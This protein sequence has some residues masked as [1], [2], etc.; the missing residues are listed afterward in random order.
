[1]KTPLEILRARFGYENF[2][3][4]QEEVIASVLQKR[5]TFVL[6]PTGGGKSLCYQIP[7]LVFD[8]L[9]VVI[10]PL[11]A[12][13]KDQVDALRLNGVAA[14]YLNSTLSLDQQEHIKRQLAENKLKLLY[15]APERLLSTGN[16]F[17]AFLRQL[18]IS[19]IAIDEAHCISQWGHDFRPEYL[20]LA[21]LKKDL[22]GVPIIALTATADKLTRKDILEKLELKN[23]GVYVS[24]FNRPNIRYT[25]EPK[26][27]NFERLIE[28]L[29]DHAND[30]G[31]IYCLSRAS[32]EALA[33]DLQA[34]GFKALPYHAGLDREVR[35][36]HQDLFVKD[37]VKIVVATIAFGMGIDKSN[38]RFVVHMDLP[39]SIEGYYQETGRAGRDGLES[40]AVLFFGAGDVMKL[41]KFAMVEGNDEQ[42]RINLMKLDHM[43]RYGDAVTCRRKYL[44]NYFDESASDHCGNC[45]VCLSRSDMFDG[46]TIAQKALSAVVRVQERFGAGY[47]IDVLRGSASEKIREEHRQLKT[48][49]VGADISKETW[50]RYLNELI[51]RD[52]LR[53]SEGVY[54]VLQLGQKASG[55]LK[56]TEKVM[57][58]FQKQ[59]V[60][61]TASAERYQHDAELFEQLRTLRK[62]L[63][64]EENVPAY[65]VLSDATLVE[66]ATYYPHNLSEVSQVSGFGE[67][68]VEKY[69]KMFSEV[70]VQYCREKNLTSRIHLKKPKRQR[71]ASTEKIER[72]T[73]TR[74]RTLE[75][76][77]SGKSVQ[78]I[79]S[80]RKL[81]VSTIENH[82][83]SYIEEGSLMIDDFVPSEKLR[84]ILMAIEEKGDLRLAP[85]KETLGE[86]FSYGE[87]RMAVAH[88][89]SQRV[90]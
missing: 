88:L 60:T 39:K 55:V 48:F 64:Q 40:E 81:S 47:I 33:T 15:L 10:S 76:Y 72:V 11:I 34:H 77:R 9:T 36:K 7:A 25:V 65:I 28:F 49:G 24:S 70:V 67:M 43:A 26:K 54:P 18:T 50:Q 90:A 84:T 80:H 8:G 1:M 71:K 46:T 57:L 16:E 82:L 38:V 52:Y 59:F 62:S 61:P 69:G 42:T 73:D 85:I 37:E 2:R 53:K 17:I 45:D 13:M 6:M 83:A 29:S 86:E 89:K 31:I 30:S 14:A 4:K 87:I 21:R 58:T 79:A 27:G 41:K 12:L 20:M 78:E 19:L 56:G 22:P 74:Y 32:T 35:T 66:L 5:D 51:A 63:A 75:L 3:L 23:P 68:K 44:L